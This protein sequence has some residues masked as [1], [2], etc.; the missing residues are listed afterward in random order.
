[1]HGSGAPPARGSDPAPMP[2]GYPMPDGGIF[3]PARAAELM[4]PVGQQYPEN[5]DWNAA[6][7]GRARAVPPWLLA[8][9]FIGAIGVALLLTVVVARLI[10]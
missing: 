4:S 3:D 10:H 7:S 8:A 1:M 9:L 5:V 6:A 2:G